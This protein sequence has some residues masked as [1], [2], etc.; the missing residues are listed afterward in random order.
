MGKS[1][2][3]PFRDFL[4]NSFALYDGA[5]GTLLQSII[6]QIE[7]KP[8]RKGCVDA[9]YLYNPSIIEKIHSE[10]FEA[11]SNVVET[12]TFGSNFFKLKEYN[13]ENKIE[14][15]NIIAVN[16]ARRVAEY[17]FE[18]TGIPRYVALSVGP[19]GYL[20][21][22]DEK[23]LNKISYEE[24]FDA[25]YRQIFPA[26]NSGVDIILIETGQDLLEV[27]IAAEVALKI[28]KE[29][30]RDDLFIQVQVTLDKFG[31]MLLG[32]SIDAVLAALEPLNIDAIGINCSTGPIE[33]EKSLAYLS[34][35]A[36][37]FVSC[38]PNAG[39]PVNIEGKALY[40]LD[41]EK[42]ASIFAP[43]IKKYNLNIV[44]GCCG[45]TPKHIK[46]LKNLLANYKPSR[47]IP[48][49]RNCIVSSPFKS[50]DVRYLKKPIII[51]ERLNAQGSRKTREL[52]VN[53]AF[54]KLLDIARIQYEKGASLLDICTANNI[55]GKEKEL[56]TSLVRKISANIPIPIVPDTTE[57]DVI[58]EVFKYNAGRI[59]I[60]SI[61][62]E[63]GKDKATE[64]LNIAKKYGAMVIAL[65]IDER[66]MAK[67]V[68]R[69]LEIVDRIIT[70]A[71]EVNFPIENLIF[72]PLV[73]TLATGEKEY[74]NS[75]IHT[76]QSIKKIKEKYPY[77]FTSLGISNV[78][79]GFK[80]PARKILNNVF[81]IESTKAGLDFAIFNPST[82][83]R[84]KDIEKK[85]YELAF[86][87]IY[88]QH[89]K[90][91]EEFIEYFEN[92]EIEIKK[93]K[94]ENFSLEEQLK[95]AIIYRKKSNLQK[96]LEEAL[97]KYSA[98]EI[99]NQILLPAMQV[100]GDKMEKGEV[101]LPY[102]LQSAEILKES[103]AYLEN[104]LPKD[105]QKKR[106]KIILATVYGDVHDIGKNLVKTILSNNGFEVIDLG[107]QV[108]TDDIIE[109]VKKYNP[110]A[111]G[112]SALL[113]TTSREMATCVRKFY[114]ENINIPI[115]IGGAAVSE[116]YAK[117]IA[118]LPDG[119]KYVGGVYYAKDAFA[120]IKILDKILN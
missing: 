75:A 57:I 15:I 9:I 58:K 94:I 92:K 118:I 87:L 14:E 62:L 85:A 49:K 95:N 109:A 70:I 80:P 82:L 79:F 35:N 116:E 103:L 111:V 43:I 52:L 27:R 13:L 42:F 93:I 100:V 77:V 45:T 104:F 36:P 44:G 39:I 96:N 78:S 47:N 53:Y 84:K 40:S 83:L 23:S 18:K 38:L 107:K 112:L 19:T 26:A 73:F 25:Y 59:I 28:K 31:K 11:G 37:F 34:E 50:F 91:L 74:M 51:G 65:T 119:S 63:K 21:S 86:N 89:E 102:V 106:G 110:D 113:I 22:S 60:N 4:Q 117:K 114:E 32:S 10:Y 17:Y 99:I 101:I 1:Y 66:G 3:E 105:S 97:K 8:V 69:K 68:D 12:N 24:I 55:I 90:A 81:L 5:M 20:I 71:K 46:K 41:A 48:S 2:F 67:T 76:L 98:V 54:D 29:L 72:D 16:T 6:P 108:P 115:F 120:C 33:M 88:N 56:M 30:N 61:N 64:I 7:S